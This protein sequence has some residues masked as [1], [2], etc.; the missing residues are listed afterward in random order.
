M[1]KLI[2]SI[3]F[4]LFFFLIPTEKIVA[5]STLNFT[6]VSDTLVDLELSITDNQHL[7]SSPDS[8]ITIT[9]SVFNNSN[10]P[11]TGIW[12]K[13]YSDNCLQY[14]S[15]AHS[16]GS[17]IANYYWLVGTLNPFETAYFDLEV[18]QTNSGNC[19]FLAHVSNAGEVDVD[20]NPDNV[21]GFAVN[22]EDDE[23]MTTIQH[24]CKHGDLSLQ[25]DLSDVNASPGDTISVTYI[26]T[27]DGP[28]SS[29]DVRMNYNLSSYTSILSFNATDGV[30]Y[31]TNRWDIPPIAAGTSDTL[32]YEL[33]VENTT[34]TELSFFGQITDYNDL[35]DPDSSENNDDGDQSEDDEALEKVNLIDAAIDLELNLLHDNIFAE[36]VGDT[37]NFTIELFNDSQNSASGI[38]VIHPILSDFDY[39]DINT[40]TGSFDVNTGIWNIG[41]ISANDTVNMELSL[42]LTEASPI[43]NIDNF[44][45]EVVSANES[46][47]DSSP[48]NNE[49]NEDD[50]QSVEIYK[51]SGFIDLELNMVATSNFI[52]NGMDLTIFVTI[53][54]NSINDA[55]GVKVHNII[56]DNMQFV[57]ALP[58][59]GAYDQNLNIWDVGNIAANDIVGIE[60][61]FQNLNQ[62]SFSDVYVFESQVMLANE[63][64]VDSTPNNDDGDHSEDD[65][66]F[67]AV[68][69]QCYNCG[70]PQADLELSMDV[71]KYFGTNGELF[72][73]T[74]DVWV[75]QNGPFDATDGVQVALNLPNGFE[76]ISVGPYSPAFDMS[77]NIWNVG[78]VEIG[79]P[80]K[81]LEVLISATNYSGLANISA[82]V[83]SS[84]VNDY[85]STPNNDDGDQS[86]DDE[87]AVVIAIDSDYVDL[88]LGASFSPSTIYT[89]D[90][91][92]YT[93]KLI[94]ESPNQANG[95]EVYVNDEVSL[96][97]VQFYNFLSQ[98]TNSGTYDSN[99]KIWNVGS[100]APYDTLELMLEYEFIGISSL[101]KS[102]VAEV[103]KVNEQDLDSTPD[104]YI[105]NAVNEDDEIGKTLYGRHFCNCTQ[106]TG[107]L[108]LSMS[109]S[110]TNVEVGETFTIDIQVDN[111]SNFYDTNI[112]VEYVPPQEFIIL[113]TSSNI[114]NASYNNNFWIIDFLDANSSELISFELM[115]VSTALSPVKHIAQISGSSAYH[116]IDS[117]VGNDDGDQSEDDEDNVWI[118]VNNSSN[119]SKIF[120]RVF[121][122]GYH[123]ISGQ[124]QQISNSGYNLIP[125]SQP[126][127]MAP[128]FYNGTESVS[129]IPAG[130]VDW[131]LLAC[132][133][134]DGNI[135]EYKAGFIDEDGFIVDLLGQLGIAVSYPYNHFSLH[136]KGHLAVMSNEQ[137]LGN[138]YDFTN[139]DT[140]AYGLEQLKSNNNAF[141]M[142]AGDYDNNG[143]INNLDF[144]A[145]ENNSAAVNQ[146]LHFDADGNGIINNL[147]YNFWELNRSKVG[148]LEIQY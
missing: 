117:W 138:V 90:S 110:A 85:D 11:A 105:S 78:W 82:E 107:D 119:S 108:E 6:A 146:Y 54:N 136:H 41:N 24:L 12:I 68:Y 46:D 63:I 94:N 3:T 52:Y 10:V 72:E 39:V 97:T 4:L 59:I 84:S 95:V 93:L 1:K 32:S 124:V 34:V 71:D 14:I 81:T 47:I 140:S 112:R 44:L 30:T 125:L 7:I 60:L 74:I 147:D 75:D 51:L 19:R 142:Y 23:V 50:L 86:E 58:E 67:W 21:N 148:A 69:S 116:D 65:E 27:N 37:L 121:L 2:Y 53:I 35:C 98:S 103:V 134:V 113:N 115:A 48:N 87:D 77:T 111:K 15:C 45:V 126:F 61:T 139:S 55:S 57:N 104:N 66:S 40:N 129:Q 70:E 79:Y 101:Q 28:N 9:V 145:W 100:I 22:N 38:Q 106:P 132:R 144:N 131:I 143:I 26:L 114:T 83:I 18:L 16:Q 123:A 89:T 43:S 29:Y 96:Y 80:Y 76:V 127:N 122:E 20:S 99:T 42:I 102:I 128:W 141:V 17:D 36:Q 120:S 5:N 56:P 73:L 92:V 137:F 62:D 133:D 91:S 109:A 49:P 13:Y 118:T 33:L 8:T 135:I 64:D 88:S 130:V 25:I 31:F